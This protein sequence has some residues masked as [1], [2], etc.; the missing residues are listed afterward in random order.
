MG[1]TNIP[2]LHIRYSTASRARPNDHRQTSTCCKPFRKLNYKSHP[3]SIG[4]LLRMRFDISPSIFARPLLN[5]RKLVDRHR[6]M[7]Y[8][9]FRYPLRLSLHSA[10]FQ[11]LN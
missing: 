7:L 2:D 10:A 11:L 6:R 3:S 4:M 1:R 9:K 5:H 8:C